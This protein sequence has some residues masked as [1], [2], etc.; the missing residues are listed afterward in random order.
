MFKV[1]DIDSLKE[2][3]VD[4]FNNQWALVTAGSRDKF[5]TMTVSWGALGELWNMDMATVYIRESRYTKE[6]CDSEDY[7]SVS[8]YPEE[9]KKQIHSVCGSKS[10]RDINK[11]EACG[12][13]PVFDE[14]APYF[15]QAKLVLI[16]KK[17][18]I[19]KFTP[20]NFIDGSIINNYA[21][22]D[23]HYIYYGKIEKVLISE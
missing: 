22:N 15:E 18:A 12:L 6:F 19:S 9:L 2:S 5:N 23:F 10:G 14:S 13:T 20:D 1:I 11:A 7:F 21:D 16:C 17:V 3:A 4:L 8:V